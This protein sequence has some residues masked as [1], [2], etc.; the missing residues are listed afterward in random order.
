VA[1]GAD[2][3]RSLHFIFQSLPNEDQVS[4]IGKIGSLAGVN[5]C[6]RDGVPASNDMSESLD[7]TAAASSECKVSVQ[8]NC[9][10]L[11]GR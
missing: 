6:L 10:I 2:T 1:G 3:D 7:V 4:I 5:K 9:E 8:Y 11:K